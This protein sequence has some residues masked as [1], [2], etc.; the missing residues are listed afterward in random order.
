MAKHLF[1][2]C[3]LLAAKLAQAQPGVE[4]AN[5]VFGYG[6]GLSFSSGQPV[7]NVHSLGTPEGSASISDPNTGQLLFYTDGSYVWGGNNQLMPNGM[8]L[9]SSGTTTQAALIVP[10]PGNNKIYYIITA[11]QGGYNLTPNR[12]V[13]YSEIDMTLNNGLGDVTI[14]NQ[15]LTPPPTTEKLVGVKHCNGQDYWIITHPFYSDAFYAY[16]VTPNGINTTPVISNVGSM[17]DDVSGG[18]YYETIGYMKAS[19]NGK[20]LAVGISYYS[21][22]LEIFDFDN[23]TGK[24]SNPITIDYAGENGPYGISFSPDN[25]KLYAGIIIDGLL[26]QYDLTSNNQSQII[27]SETL[28]DITLYDGAIQMG[29][30]GKLYVITGLSYISVIQDPN[31]AGLNC[32]LSTTPISYNYQAMG[33]GLPNFMDGGLNNWVFQTNRDTVLCGNQGQVTLHG[34]AYFTNHIWSTGA[35]TP[36]ISV[37]SSGTYWVTSGTPGCYVTDS[38]TVIVHNVIDTLKDISQCATSV[39]VDA[40]YPGVSSY[41]WN[42]G[43]ALPV[44]TFAAQGAYWV[45]YNY[46][47]GCGLKDYFSINL[48]NYFSE[49]QIP[50]IVTP[51]ADGINDVIDF[52]KF[53]LSLLQLNIFDRWG[54]KIFESGDTHCV[55]A[56]NVTDGTYYYTLTYKAICSEKS[57]D[58]KGFITVIK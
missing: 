18:T 35:T 5:W 51:N 33:L 14:K 29:S 16:Q 40:T 47:D 11:D 28:I 2:L 20:K 58:T 26:Y 15:L 24:V 39:T 22:M 34:D 54:V 19:P 25:T 17:H 31:N 21:P 41:V 53:D 8:G 38:V 3:V 45:Q 37:D 6:G 48:T 12:G 55:W 36:S 9:M 13:H 42:D 44:H 52:G 4:S 46:A 50:N 23:F 57:A 27:G 7:T 32:H 1:L 30:D 10:K 43:Q 56:P 49:A